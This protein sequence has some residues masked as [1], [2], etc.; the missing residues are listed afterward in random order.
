MFHLPQEWRKRIIELWREPGANATKI[1]DK[2][3]E[4]GMPVPIRRIRI[5]GQEDG[6]DT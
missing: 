5:V 3:G 2:L 6:I 1:Q 4:E